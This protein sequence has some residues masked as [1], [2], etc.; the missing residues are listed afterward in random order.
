TRRG[1]TSTGSDTL[2][3]HTAPTDDSQEP[4]RGHTRVAFRPGEY[5]VRGAYLQE[6]QGLG[7]KRLLDC[8]I[9]LCYGY[10]SSLRCRHAPRGRSLESHPARPPVPRDEGSHGGLRRL[11]AAG[12]VLFRLGGAP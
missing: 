12:A 5:R 1:R 7:N 6:T 3:A 9:P 10:G 4:P 11:G 2:A 8:P